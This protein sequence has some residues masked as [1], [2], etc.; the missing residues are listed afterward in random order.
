MSII[1]KDTNT[2]ENV[3]LPKR[4]YR[5]TDGDNAGKYRLLEEELTAQEFQ[6]LLGSLLGD[7]SLKIHKNYKNARFS[8]R[9]SI[10]QQE[11]FYWKAEALKR[12]ASDKSIWLQKATAA[13]YSS[14]DKL[15]FQTR[16][17][18]SLTALYNWTHKRG[19]LGR[20]RL[21]RSWLN[22][23]GPEGL[24][25]WWCDDGSV[26]AQGRQ[27]VFATDSFCHR[28]LLVLQKYLLKVWGL[29]LNIK[30]VRHHGAPVKKLNGETSHRMYFASVVDFQKFL[31][32]ILPHI[33]VKSM[34]YKVAFL[35]RNSELQ[36]RWI[37]YM[38]E[39]SIFNEDV[40]RAVIAERKAA[41]ASPLLSLVKDLTD[42]K[43]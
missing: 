9:H 37:S 2:L 20:V 3:A 21:W 41:L 18:A 13:E 38:I 27:G 15:R 26:I 16:A 22:R 23:L 42:N 43:K 8:M 30:E 34:L 4:F 29:R 5:E 14:H 40:I 6:I 12:L 28:D 11:Y 7:G 25:I 17:L 10:K 1:K 33:P 19:S 32:I 39:S 36:E 35:Y 24:A 31:Q